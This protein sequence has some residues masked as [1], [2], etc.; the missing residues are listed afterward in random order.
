MPRNRKESMFF[1][2]MMCT[3][4]VLGMSLYNSCLHKGIDGLIFTELLLGFIPGFFAALLLDV[5]LVGPNA[6]KLAFKLLGIHKG[7]MP[8]T[9]LVISCCMVL[10]MV[11]CMSLFGLVLQGGFSGNVLLDY[12]NAVKLNIL[13]ALPLQL[14]VAGPVSRYYLRKFQRDKTVY[15][16]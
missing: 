11:L 13:F 7:K 10:G 15:E 14:V 12:L 3:I 8:I 4:M 6:K 5:F 16:N 2:L 9:P 1:T